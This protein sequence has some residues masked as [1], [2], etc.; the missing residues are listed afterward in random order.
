M[1]V[2]RKDGRWFIDGM[3]KSDGSFIDMRGLFAGALLER[4]V[5]EDISGFKT[6]V[7]YS[8]PDLP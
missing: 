8:G 6:R 1:G 4:A 3:F 5:Q 7:I 2:Y